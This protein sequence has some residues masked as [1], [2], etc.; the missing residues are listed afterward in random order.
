[1]Y[2]LYGLDKNKIK[3]GLLVTLNWVPPTSLLK[4]YS[5]MKLPSMEASRCSSNVLAYKILQ[6][7]WNSWSTKASVWFYA[8]RYYQLSKATSTGRI[9]RK[10]WTFNYCNTRRRLPAYL[11]SIFLHTSYSMTALP[12]RVLVSP[13]VQPYSLKILSIFHSAIIT[14]Y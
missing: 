12:N 5:S 2:I 6:I 10:T 4:Q 7:L 14:K 11:V 3:I 1:M 8:G 13:N 9:G